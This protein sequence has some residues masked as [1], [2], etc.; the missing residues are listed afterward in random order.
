MSGSIYMG[1][2]YRP[3]KRIFLVVLCRMKKRKGWS[4]MNSSESVNMRASRT[5]PVAAAASVPSSFT[6]TKA[7]WTTLDMSRSFAGDIPI[8]WRKRAQKSVIVFFCFLRRWCFTVCVLSCTQRNHAGDSVSLVWC[9]SPE[10]SLLV[11]SNA[12]SI[13]MLIRSFFK[14]YFSSILNRGSCTSTSNFHILSGWVQS[15]KFW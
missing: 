5:R 9:V 2:Q 11:L 3:T 7:L 10:K 12:S 14:S 8:R 1:E 13:P 4:A 6:S 15:T